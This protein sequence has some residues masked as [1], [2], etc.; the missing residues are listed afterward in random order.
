MHGP[1]SRPL[2]GNMYNSSARDA[3]GG[4][5]RLIGE[6]RPKLRRYRAPMAGSA[7]YGEVC[8]T[9]E[10]RSETFCIMR[11]NLCGESS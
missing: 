4:L 2:R 3:A 10:E 6:L 11:Q 5:D 9:P 7:M 1:G 8:G